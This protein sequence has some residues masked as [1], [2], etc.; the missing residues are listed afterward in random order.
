MYLPYA[1]TMVADELHLEIV[2][3]RRLGM[4]IRPLRGFEGSCSYQSKVV[5][6]L[7]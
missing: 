4:W 1:H 5:A 3:R 7:R 6:Q 2:M